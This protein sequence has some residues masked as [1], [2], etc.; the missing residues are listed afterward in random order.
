MTPNGTGPRPNERAKLHR[1]VVLPAVFMLLFLPSSGGS[2]LRAQSADADGMEPVSW[3]SG[4]GISASA[5]LTSLQIGAQIEMV[6]FCFTASYRTLK[7]A[8]RGYGTP[9]VGS[10]EA[11]IEQSGEA[12]FSL[13]PSVR[14]FENLLVTAGPEMLWSMRRMKWW[15]AQN[16]ENLYTEE[17]AEF[18]LRWFAS[19]QAGPLEDE[20]WVGVGYGSH[21]SLFLSFILMFW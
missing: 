10:V 5:G 14:V 17:P 6:N 11:G 2:G 20:L 1:S 13:A 8:G 4:N 16:G 15:N 3:M 19:L 18:N 21:R 12:G 9:P 7:M